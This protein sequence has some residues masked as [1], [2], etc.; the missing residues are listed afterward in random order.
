MPAHDMHGPFPFH[1]EVIERCIDCDK[2]GN[3][4]LGY[5][6]LGVFYVRKVGRGDENL[7]EALYEIWD[8]I[9]HRYELFFFRYADS[10]KD[11]FDYHCRQY[12]HYLA[13]DLDE[14]TPPEPPVNSTRTCPICG[15]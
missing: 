15:A 2:P 11:A 14:Q 6:E 1:K 3:Y 10:S 5:E 8:I 7:R 12:H 4:A 13:K 9:G